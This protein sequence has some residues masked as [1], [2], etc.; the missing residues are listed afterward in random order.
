MKI[1]FTQWGR[2]VDGE[3]EHMGSAYLNEREAIR[4]VTEFCWALENTH[5]WYQ[6]AG[7]VSR[8]YD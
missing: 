5:G 6:S 8:L 7:A 1:Q 3:R 4:L 2:E